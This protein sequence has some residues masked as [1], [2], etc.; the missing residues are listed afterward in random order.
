MAQR[1]RLIP[2]LINDR[3]SGFI[4]FYIGNGNPDK[5]V[6]DDMWSVVDDEPE[7]NICYIDHL[8]TDKSLPNRNKYAISVFRYFTKCIKNRFPKVNKL[9]WNRVKGGVSHVRNKCIK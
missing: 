9:R 1:N 7:G 6:R 5:Y 8:I 3:L 4:T 2:I